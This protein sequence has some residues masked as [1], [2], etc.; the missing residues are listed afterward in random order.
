MD[1]TIIS[2]I[3]YK[4]GVGKTVSSF[5]I[6]FGLAF[7]NSAR[8]LLID[9]DPQCSLSTICLN[10]ISR[11][12]GENIDL[13]QLSEEQT[14]NSV[15]KDYLTT[16][17]N[18]NPN[19]NLDNIITKIPYKRHNGTIFENVDFISAT[20]FDNKDNYYERGLDDL[21][22]EIVRNYSNKISD[23]NL[24]TIFSRFLLDTKINEM[25]DFI[26]F[27]CPPANN[28]ITQNALAVSDFYLIPTIMDS[29]SSNGINH[30]I[31]LIDNSIFAGLYQA[32]KG[33]IDRCRP[34]SQYYC[35]KNPPRLLGIFE[36]LRKTIV[37]YNNREIVKLRFGDYLFD[38]IIYDHKDTGDYTGD[39]YSCFSLNINQN[40]PQYAPHTNYGNLVLSILKRLGIKK[41]N[42][43]V[44][45]NRVC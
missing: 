35:L 38:E 19:I 33:I 43:G 26:I 21:E 15:I 6:G 36:T 41:N 25:Y 30:L 34:G 2:M 39:G 17:E 42:N 1:S 45:I 29:L 28:I 14:I 24:V 44:R 9:L 4:G 40:N 16:G 27:D 12:R 11:S 32:N 31:N 37:K 8:V 3:N 18:N 13:S 23:I 22:I 20:M 5:N 7:L 10:A